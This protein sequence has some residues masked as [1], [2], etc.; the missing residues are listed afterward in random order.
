VHDT[1][2]A[3]EPWIRICEI[4]LDGADDGGFGGA[5]QALYALRIMSDGRI[6]ADDFESGDSLL[7]RN[8]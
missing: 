1:R 7:G 2:V 8:V 6:F 5:S 4:S 3:A